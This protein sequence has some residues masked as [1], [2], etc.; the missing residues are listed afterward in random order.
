MIPAGSTGP[1]GTGNGIFA[2]V[3]ANQLSGEG[4]TSFNQVLSLTLCQQVL[5]VLIDPTGARY[6]GAGNPLGLD[7]PP[8]SVKSQIFYLREP[9][10]PFAHGTDNT[11]AYKSWT[12]SNF[13]YPAYFF[14]FNTS[15]IYDFLGNSPA[16]FT[17]YKGS[18]FSI[19]QTLVDADPHV[20]IYVSSLNN[21]YT[22]VQVDMGSIYTYAGWGLTGIAVEARPENVSFD[23]VG[24]KCRAALNRLV[25]KLPRQ[26]PY[27]AIKG[28][29]GMR[30]MNSRQFR[31][32]SPAGVK[33]S[34]H[35]KC[36]TKFN[37]KEP[38]LLPFQ[39]ISKDGFLVSRFAII[40]YIP[41]KLSPTDVD[42]AIPVMEQY[43]KDL[44]LPYWNTTAK[45]IGNYTI[46]SDADLPTFDGTFIPFF[47]LNVGQFNTTGLGPL[48]VGGG[49]TN[50]NNVTNILAGP[51]I[52]E[53]L[54]PYGGFSVPNLPLANP[55]LMVSE[56]NFPGQV[57]ITTDQAGVGP[58]IGLPA[59]S[60]VFPINPSYPI[61]AE[62]AVASPDINACTPLTPGS[63]TGKI[64]I[65][66]RGSCNSV[67]YPGIM[68][69]AGAIAYITIFPPGAQA[70]ASPGATIP[71][72]TVG[73]D[74]LALIAAVEANPNL[75]IT[76]SAPGPSPSTIQT[77]TALSTHEAQE[78]ASDPTYADYIATS[79]PP[80]DLAI[81]FSQWEA[82]D[83]IERLSQSFTQGSNTYAMQGFPL[84]SYFT[85]SLLFYSYDNFGT[86]VRPLVPT[87]RQQIVF[88][89]QGQPL[90]VGNVFGPTES[91][92]SLLDL[93]D[94]GSI[95]NR[96]A[97]YAPYATPSYPNSVET[98]ITD[99]PLA[100]IYDNLQ[101]N[102]YP[103]F[104]P[105][106]SG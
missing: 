39:Y 94:S 1:T 12:M 35:K 73:A 93:S 43:M 26:Y 14:P 20:V 8:G 2:A 78:L 15:G 52:T 49:A 41:G 47:Y 45:F 72:Y 38:Q 58:F 104:E 36:H 37:P 10:A 83:A 97:F 106:I 13:A 30:A 63:M 92:L 76:I 24:N 105:S 28:A 70:F 59:G 34:K 48:V 66:I 90:H 18:Q 29:H 102:Q 96:N 99:S 57:T 86:M 40:N 91:A 95:F 9:T 19:T 42:A 69:D 23:I 77:F 7:A 44:Y 100:S 33:C 82:A 75:V 61:V 71:G 85:Q 56:T 32:L 87:S 84:P 55:Y 51:L 98:P 4:P 60:T 68:A 21:P 11:F 79:N 16:P 46:T 3:A 25:P 22:I 64:G 17:P 65:N 80:I 54:Q 103:L 89:Q 62:G 74:G 27:K 67:V 6:V 88:Q 81:L 50:V 101:A 31:D 53:Y 5:S